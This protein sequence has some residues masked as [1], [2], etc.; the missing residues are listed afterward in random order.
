MSV[1][2]SQNA[3]NIVSISNDGKLCQWKP[4]MLIEPSNYCELQ[5]SAAAAPAGNYANR[6]GQ[7]LVAGIS[8]GGANQ[9]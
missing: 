6:I 3:H 1:V 9:Q 4:N 8:Q 5:T 2:G 7:N